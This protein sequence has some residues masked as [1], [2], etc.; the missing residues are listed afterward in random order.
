MIPSISESTFRIENSPEESQITPTRPFR[1]KLGNDLNYEDFGRYETFQ[2]M[3]EIVFTKKAY[4]PCS[5]NVSTKS[6]N[7]LHWS[8]FRAVLFECAF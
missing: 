5:L 4:K 1:K 2:C 6:E 3:S 7:P 8:L